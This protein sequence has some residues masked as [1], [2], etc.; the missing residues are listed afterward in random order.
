MVAVGIGRRCG[1][2]GVRQVGIVGFR[3]EIASFLQSGR[4][5]HVGFHPVDEALARHILYHL[6][7]KLICGVGVFVGCPR[8]KGERIVVDEIFSRFVSQAVQPVVVV[9]GECCGVAA[10][11]VFPLLLGAWARVGDARRV[12]QK[13]L[14]GYFLI[15]RVAQLRHEFADGVVELQAAFFR[16]F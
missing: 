3:L 8:R 7:H 15:A 11:V 12:A 2:V 14:K 5:E 16:K 9:V 1:Y 6:Q 4:G 13:M 10:R